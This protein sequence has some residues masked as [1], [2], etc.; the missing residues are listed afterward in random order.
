[1]SWDLGALAF[2]DDSIDISR[3]HRLIV[4]LRDNVIDEINQLYFE[5][6]GLLERLAHPGEAPDLDRRAL[7]LRADELAAGLDAWTEPGRVTWESFL[8]PWERAHTSSRASV[9][10]SPSRAR[11]TVQVGG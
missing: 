3:E 4:S 2:D 7:Q 9:T 5:R 6:L 11:P 1:M 8:G 10:P